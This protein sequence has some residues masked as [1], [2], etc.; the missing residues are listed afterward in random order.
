MA[1]IDRRRAGPR[2]CTSRGAAAP[3]IVLSR[4]PAF[5]GRCSKVAASATAAR[6]SLPFHLPC[7]L[8][9][10]SQVVLERRQRT[11]GKC[12]QVGIVTVARLGI[13]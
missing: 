7:D 11:P 13:E 4:R 5:A 8:L 10:R 1:Q 2:H 3:R 12:A 9:R 6:A